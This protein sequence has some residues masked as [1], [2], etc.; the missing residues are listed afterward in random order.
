MILVLTCDLPFKVICDFQGQTNTKHAISA[1]LLPVE[2]QYVLTP[3]RKSWSRS[4]L[5]K[6]C[7]IRFIIAC[8]QSK[9]RPSYF[10]I[11]FSL[12]LEGLRKFCELATHICADLRPYKADY[13]MCVSSSFQVTF[14]MNERP[15][16]DVL[17]NR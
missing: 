1:L 3:Y 15:A 6:T 9:I 17:N 11:L 13:Y 8:R 12:C 5:Y 2:M 14:L 4:N 10:L 7:D 16:F